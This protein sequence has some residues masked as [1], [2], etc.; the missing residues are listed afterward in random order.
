MS[1]NCN[2][3]VEIPE[4]DNTPLVC[5]EFIPSGCILYPTAIPELMLPANSTLTLIIDN[6]MLA[7]IDAKARIVILEEK[8]ETL[9]NP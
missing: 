8:V 5:D 6:L 2:E 1:T 7:L 3:Q 4:V 9:E